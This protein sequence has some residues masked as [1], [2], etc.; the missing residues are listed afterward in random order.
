MTDSLVTDRGFGLVKQQWRASLLS[1]VGFTLIFTLLLLLRR[2]VR[3]GGP[4]PW[5]W[6]AVHTMSFG[7]YWDSASS[8]LP[9]LA[10]LLC[11]C[12]STTSP[13][14]P[15]GDSWGGAWFPPGRWLRLYHLFLLLVAWL[16]VASPFGRS[17][18][19][20]WRGSPPQPCGFQGWLVFLLGL[21]SPAVFFLVEAS[22]IPRSA[23]CRIDRPIQLGR[24]LLV[25]RVTGISSRLVQRLGP[26]Y[27]LHRG[28][29]FGSDTDWLL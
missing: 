5:F 7:A 12:A 24:F 21:P 27:P 18:I 1:F 20:F 14:Q 10:L 19:Q 16:L 28:C 25:C 26:G 9:C 22:C 29:G 4:F 11:I 17:L 23:D 13:P 3:V 2:S 6:T 15:I 8:L